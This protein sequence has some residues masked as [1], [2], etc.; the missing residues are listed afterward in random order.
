MC[1]VKYICA[2]FIKL[3]GN[4]RMWRWYT[5]KENKAELIDVM[6]MCI[7]HSI[8]GIFDWMHPSVSRVHATGMNKINDALVTK[9]SK[10]MLHVRVFKWF[11]FL[12][13]VHCFSSWGTWEHSIVLNDFPS[14][15]CANS[16]IAH[17]SCVW[18]TK[19]AKSRSSGGNDVNEKIKKNPTNKMNLWLWNPRLDC[20]YDLLRISLNMCLSY[21]AHLYNPNSYTIGF[22][23]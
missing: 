19:R 5:Y 1:A 8:F 3:R 15:C 10:F 12:W 16:H 22:V 17:C 23:K 18:M 2:T 11:Q 7:E 20:C 14:F 21:R 13:T 4:N 9:S 6:Y